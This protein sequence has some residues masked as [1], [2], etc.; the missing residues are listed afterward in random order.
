[1]HEE[2][3]LM[4]KRLHFH[5]GD[6]TSASSTRPIKQ[7]FKITSHSDSTLSWSLAQHCAPDGLFLLVHLTVH[8]LHSPNLHLLTTCSSSVSSLSHNSCLTFLT[9]CIHSMFIHIFNKYFTEHLPWT[10]HPSNSWRYSSEQ[11]KIKMLPSW[12]LQAFQERS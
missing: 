12:N 2:A 9:Q 5:C 3:Y 11:K 4:S 8:W 7:H 1:M 6:K 10:R